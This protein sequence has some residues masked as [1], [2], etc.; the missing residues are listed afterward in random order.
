MMRLSAMHVSFRM[1]LVAVVA[2]GSLYYR[3]VAAKTS[4]LK[5]LRLEERRYRT[6]VGEEDVAGEV[7]GLRR[8]V[9]DRR[10]AFAADPNASMLV[11]SLSHLVQDRGLEAPVLK[12]GSTR[13]TY[14]VTQSTLNVEFKGSFRAMVGVLRDLSRE[15]QAWSLTRVS[16]EQGAEMR[17]DALAMNLEIVTYACTGSEGSR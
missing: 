17:P 8:E 7:E 4:E 10:A 16:I 14:G 9:G 12:A 6:E 11:G 13:T 2:L 3:H 15:S 1:F 5:S